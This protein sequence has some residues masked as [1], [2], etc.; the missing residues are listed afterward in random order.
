MSKSEIASEALRRLLESRSRFLA[1][2]RKRIP[3]TETAEDILQNAFLKGIERGGE[4]R[5]AESIVPWFY[6]VLRNSVVDYYRQ[7]G[8]SKHELKGVL[9][10][11]EA[12]AS[13]SPEPENEI[14]Q[15]INPLLENLK[16]EYR[17]ALTTIDL[18]DGSLADLAK[19]A[20][21]TEGNAAVRVHRARQA[22]LR[23]VQL[24]CGACAEHHCVDCRCNHR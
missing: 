16:P 24:T 23:Q 10:D 19:Q 12:Y 3:S 8:R 17:K 15:C 14:C 9:A 13:T 22:M 2:L 1:F 21:I 7:A 18:G 20:G 5:D 6:R 4:V 11:L